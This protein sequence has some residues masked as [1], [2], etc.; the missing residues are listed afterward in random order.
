[1]QWQS[2]SSASSFFCPISSH[3]KT[4]AKSTPYTHY[5]A[6]KQKRVICIK[7]DVNDTDVGSESLICWTKMTPTW[8]SYGH[9]WRHFVPG[10]VV[11][12]RPKSQNQATCVCDVPPPFFSNW[13]L[14]LICGI[15]CNVGS[16]DLKFTF[17]PIRQIRNEA[18]YCRP[19]RTINI[20]SCLYFICL[21]SWQQKYNIHVM[22]H[23][24]VLWIW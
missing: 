13:W 24:A 17:C 14:I 10:Q 4:S 3:T 12:K 20:A 7:S 21:A 6:N 5:C 15:Q 1:M 11:C 8:V 23:D 9:Y 16:V 2:V 19:G 22:N 18:S